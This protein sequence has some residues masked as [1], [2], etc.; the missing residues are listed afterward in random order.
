MTGGKVCPNNLAVHILRKRNPC[1]ILF[2]ELESESEVAQSYPTLC[3]SMDTRLL[4]PWDFLDKST[5]VGCHFLLQGIFPT[6]GSN[7]GVPH[8]RHA[9]PS[10]PPGK[11]LVGT[12]HMYIMSITTF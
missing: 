5:G 6:Q 10:E 8:C 3:N 12:S 4:C 9:L 1:L 2:L 7:P 11:S